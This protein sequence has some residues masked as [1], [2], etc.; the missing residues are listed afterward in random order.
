MKK[1]YIISLEDSM[2]VAIIAR[3]RDHARKFFLHSDYNDCGLYERFVDI[4]A[5]VSKIK[6]PLD[7]SYGEIDS[8]DGLKMGV[9]SWAEGKCQICK[10]DDQRVQYE[11]GKIICDDCYEKNIETEGSN[12]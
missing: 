2:I 10:K 12:Q 9:Y 6:L 11:F 8:I 1:I 5:H 4:P 7:A 3:N